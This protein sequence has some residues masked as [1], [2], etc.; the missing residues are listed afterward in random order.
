ML[1]ERGEEVRFPVGAGDTIYVPTGVFHALRN[2]GW[3]PLRLLVLYVPGGAEQALAELPDF[4]ELAPG[5][6]P[7]W[8]RG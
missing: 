4:P 2:T 3:E 6:L 7:V 1:D 5:E 8:V